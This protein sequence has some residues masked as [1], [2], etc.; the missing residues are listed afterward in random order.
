MGERKKFYTVTCQAH[1]MAPKGQSYK[2]VIVP[3]PRKGGRMLGRAKAECP[4]C[5][6][7]RLK[8]QG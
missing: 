2:E 7:A 1:G 4:Y 3:A 8:E 6:A 5:K